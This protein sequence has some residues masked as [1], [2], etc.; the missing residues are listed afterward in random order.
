MQEQ[1][2]GQHRKWLPADAR[3]PMAALFVP[4]HCRRRKGRKNFLKKFKKMLDKWCR[5]PYTNGAPFEMHT[6]W[7]YSS[8]G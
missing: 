4:Q 3:K 1:K 7:R 2:S 6:T 5:N 8:V